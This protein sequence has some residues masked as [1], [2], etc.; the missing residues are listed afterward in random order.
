MKKP[1]SLFF[2]VLILNIAPLECMQ[3]GR[4]G[5]SRKES[6]QAR[7][8]A[9][10]QMNFLRKPSH[11][12]SRRGSCDQGITG[13]RTLLCLFMA[14]LLMTQ[15]VVA[16]SN[17]GQQAGDTS[18][19]AHRGTVALQTLL[20]NTAISFSRPAPIQFGLRE[21]DSS[22]M[23]KRISTYH[24]SF[25]EQEYT[26]GMVPIWHC[27]PTT[28]LLDGKLQ[29]YAD[30]F[31]SFVQDFNEFAQRNPVVA[32]AATKGTMVGLKTMYGSIVGGIAT[33]TPAGV[34]AGAAMGAV[35]GISDEIRG[36]MLHA[37]AGDAINSVTE[38]A[39]EH[40]AP[41]LMEYDPELTQ[42]SAIKLGSFIGAS[43]LTSHQFTAFVR[44]FPKYD[45]SS[46]RLSSK[47]TRRS[48]SAFSP[49]VAKVLSHDTSEVAAH[50]FAKQSFEEL[51]PQ[52]AQQID[53]KSILLDPEKESCVR[54]FDIK[55]SITN[56][57]Y[58]TY[59]S[60]AHDI[61]QLN[62]LQQ[63]T[64]G[65][66]ENDMKRIDFSGTAYEMNNAPRYFGKDTKRTEFSGTAYEPYM[67]NAA[68]YFQ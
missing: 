52:E 33:K 20:K 16:L 28:P 9:Q 43:L 65:G 54:L 56:T 64:Y 13:K 51:K 31:D 5:L 7:Q 18:G 30:G 34:A 55:N 23:V 39:A 3:Q 41:K 32:E 45:F 66:I 21:K 6:R 60:K 14:S 50:T 29:A 24:A 35:K 38:F 2:I 25:F 15:P 58:E 17:T 19:S 8:V 4:S 63:K 36:A 68:Q 53:L 46:I 10:K 44:H 67:N 40:I 1:L 49:E 61:L 62:N 42:E 48:F 22:K 26:C 59:T 47:A 57:P 11:R 27:Q 12:E 37:V